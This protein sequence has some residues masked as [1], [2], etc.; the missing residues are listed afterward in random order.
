VTYVDCLKELIRD[1]PETKWRALHLIRA[2]EDN[3]D[4]WTVRRV[5]KL[6]TEEEDL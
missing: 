4:A 5:E 2:L 3:P 1:N 6:L